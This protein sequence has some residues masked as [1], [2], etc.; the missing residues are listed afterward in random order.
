MQ[1]ANTAIEV[2]VYVISSPSCMKKT[3]CAVSYLD[4]CTF[5]VIPKMEHFAAV[6]MRYSLILPK[7]IVF[8]LGRNSAAF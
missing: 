5:G 1:T 3:S 6:V 8:C 4:I 7:N 2:C